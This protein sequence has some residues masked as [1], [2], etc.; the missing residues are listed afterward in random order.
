KGPAP[1][2]TTV[3]VEIIRPPDPTEPSASGV[4][5]AKGLTSVEWLAPSVVLNHSGPPA[6][7]L[8]QEA[9]YVI[10][11]QN[12]G[13]IESNS[14][15]VTNPIPAGLSFVRSEPPAFVNKAT[16]T[17]TFGA[18]P[19]GQV[20]TIQVYYTAQKTGTVSNCAFVETEEG[21]KDQKCVN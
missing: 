4:S 16:P 8:N 3:E 6:V 15:T 14:L 18:L 20:H 5:V 19:P 17:W 10:N 13:K 7:G 21:L 9:A 12:T 2:V 1:G 11:V